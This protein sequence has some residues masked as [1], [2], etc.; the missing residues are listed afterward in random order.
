MKE[1]E[2]KEIKLSL[3]TAVILIVLIIILAIILS[4]KIVTKDKR[5]NRNYEKNENS[6]TDLSMSDV[7]DILNK[8]KNITS[9]KCSYL[10]DGKETTEKYKNNKSILESKNE[11]NKN[12]IYYID[13]D[14][15]KR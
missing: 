1:E 6:I 3:G 13:Y 7:I 9:Y 10:V 12:F 11:N 8:S 14:N 5:I 4:I 2:K 15:K